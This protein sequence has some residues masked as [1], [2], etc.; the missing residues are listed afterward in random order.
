MKPAA[1][2]NETKKIKEAAPNGLRYWFGELR[3]D[4]ANGRNSTKKLPLK[5]R[6]KPNPVHALFGA[7]ATSTHDFEWS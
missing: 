7:I 4:F 1:N 2:F 3:A 5:R 6:R